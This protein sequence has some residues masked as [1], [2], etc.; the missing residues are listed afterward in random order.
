MAYGQKA[1]DELLSRYKDIA[2]LRSASSVLYWDMETKMPPRGIGLRAEQLGLLDVMSHDMLVDQKTSDLLE[3]SEERSCAGQLDDEGSRDL[4]LIRRYFN[5]ETVLPQDL[6]AETSKQ[7]TISIDAWKKA[8]ISNRFD[9]FRPELEKNIILKKRAAE[10]LMGVKGSETPYD[11][12]IDLFE[13]GMTS[14][15]ISS[16]FTEMRSGLMAIIK[17]LEDAGISPTTDTLTKRVPIEAQRNVSRIATE[18][19]G[20]D[21][22]GPNAGGRLDE[23]EHP[24]TNGY[25]DDVRI[26]THYHED[27]VMSN[28]FSVMHESGHALYEQNIPK[29]WIYRPIG[30]PCSYGIHESQSRFME[31]IVGRSQGLLRVLLRRMNDVT[32]GA[33]SGT[34]D[35]VLHTSGQLRKKDQDKDRS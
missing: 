10:L 22:S 12:M 17:E 23:T 29:R 32:N 5:E 2:V 15:K 7:Q 24:F 1:F 26:T 8:K 28:L 13:P 16:I 30:S 6:V 21:I 18:I 11:A 3:R 35:T 33:F 19:I 31:N 14:E 9:M 4:Y 20:Y 34:D 25:F 27:S